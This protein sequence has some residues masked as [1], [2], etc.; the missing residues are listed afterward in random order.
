M[1]ARRPASLFMTKDGTQHG[2]QRTAL[3]KLY[4]IGQLITTGQLA[5]ANVFSE[6]VI[7]RAICSSTQWREKK[8]DF[9]N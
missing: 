4:L 7:M 3:G 1:T 2:D 5:K 6:P 9:C 8:E